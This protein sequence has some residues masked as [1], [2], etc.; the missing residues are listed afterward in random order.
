MS[1]KTRYLIREILKM[2]QEAMSKERLSGSEH[3]ALIAA[4]DALLASLVETEEKES[5]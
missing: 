2:R 3:V 1:D 4:Y 5:A